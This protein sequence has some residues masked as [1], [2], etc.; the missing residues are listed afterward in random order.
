[1]VFF[2]LLQFYLLSKP[3][4]HTQIHLREEHRVQVDKEKEILIM[5]YTSAGQI[6]VQVIKERKKKNYLQDKENHRISINIFLLKF[7]S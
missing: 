6:I 5:H 2:Y 4:A 7:C 1:M 3:N